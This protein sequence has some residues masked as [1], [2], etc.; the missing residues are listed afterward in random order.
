MTDDKTV[1]MLQYNSRSRFMLK[2]ADELV[3]SW[4]D[5]VFFINRQKLLYVKGYFLYFQFIDNSSR[6]SAEI[7]NTYQMH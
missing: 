1:R 7:K 2:H 4:A 3:N 6:E 5:D